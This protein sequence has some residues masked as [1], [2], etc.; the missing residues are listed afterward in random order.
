MAAFMPEP[1]TLFTV[2]QRTLMGMPAPMDAWRAGACPSPAGST[3]P[4]KHFIGGS[5]GEPGAFKCRAEWQSRRA[6]VAVTTLELALQDSERRARRADNDDDFRRQLLRPSKSSRPIS[7]RRI[8]DVPAPISY[9][10]ASRSSRPPAF[11]LM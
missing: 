3:Q 2:V 6:A 1:Q 10:L 4:M 11:S 5:G 8:S 7:M 9:S